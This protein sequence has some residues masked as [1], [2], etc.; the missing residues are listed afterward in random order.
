MVM[1]YFGQTDPVGQTL[2]L[3]IGL[4]DVQD[5]TVAGVLKDVPDR[6]HFKFDF[7][8][9]LTNRTRQTERRSNRFFSPTFM[10]NRMAV[11]TYLLLPE[12]YAIDKLE[13]KLKDLTD[14]LREALQYVQKE[15]S[16]YGFFFNRLHRSIFI[17]I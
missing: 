5:L 10:I 14:P 4:K 15:G 17:R 1:K 7:L 16:V 3:K 11:H 12:D 6:S 13:Q 8:V 2:T 9:S